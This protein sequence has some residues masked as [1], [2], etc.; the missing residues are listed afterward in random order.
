M[1]VAAEHVESVDASNFARADYRLHS[2]AGDD[3]GLQH[4]A[5]D[6]SP[7]TWCFLR[8]P[9]ALVT[10]RSRRAARRLRSVWRDRRPSALGTDLEASGPG[11][12]GL[13]SSLERFPRPGDVAGCDAAADIPGMAIRPT[14]IRPA[15]PSRL[16]V[17]VGTVVKL[18]A[19]GRCVQAIDR[20][21]LHIVRDFAERLVAALLARRIGEYSAARPP[22]M[23]STGGACDIDRV[24]GVTS[25]VGGCLPT[26]LIVEDGMITK[27]VRVSDA[28]EAENEG[29]PFPRRRRCERRRSERRCRAAA[30]ARPPQTAPGDV[31]D[32]R[33]Y[34]PDSRLYLVLHATA[35]KYTCQAD[36]T[37]LF[38]DPEATLYKTTGAPKPVGTTFST[39]RPG[40]PCGT[41]RR[42]LRRGRADAER[43][44]RRQEHRLAAPASGR[45][46]SVTA[47][48]DNMD[49]AA[50]HDRRRGSGRDVY[51]RR[52]GRGARTAPTTSSGGRPASGP[53]AR[54]LLQV[55][56]VVSV[57]DRRVCGACSRTAAN[58]PSR[59][60][61]C[62]HSRRCADIR[63]FRTMYTLFSAYLSQIQP[64]CPGSAYTAGCEWRGSRLGLLGRGAGT[65]SRWRTQSV[66]ARSRS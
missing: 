59:V 12:T 52:H 1:R 17:D 65:F 13:P 34:A 51:A 44:G 16:L 58:C 21:A 30:S 22:G 43:A 49:P 38:T 35:S 56:R 25:P 29:K 14:E 39:S 57:S 23:P 66:P 47:R 4:P 15:A 46:E 31:L 64:L 60:L 28:Q 53:L 8:R 7:A 6:L 10:A 55:P 27:S 2:T 50:E 62:E 18:G 40:G 19:G 9:R 36:G 20:L 26:H 54:R 11:V 24:L 45:D 61:T 37:W 41:G 3:L 42:Q 63:S 48:A 32:P 5:P 33:T